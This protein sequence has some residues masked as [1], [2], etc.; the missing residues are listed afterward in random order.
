MHAGACQRSGKGGAG[1]IARGGVLLLTGLL[2]CSCSAIKAKVKQVAVDELANSLSSGGTVYSGDDSPYLIREATPFGLKLMETLLEASPEN[3]KLLSAV[4]QNF[5]QY[6]YAFVK[7]DAD[8]VEDEDLDEALELRAEARKLLLRGRDYALKGLET[9]HRGFS[10]Q[11]R[12]DPKRA[13]AKLTRQDVADAYWAG[14]AWGAAV[15]LA[16][17]DPSSLGDLP[18]VEA[19]MERV[20]RLQESFDHG[21]VHG[22]FISYEMT[23]MGDT[24]DNAQ[25]AR[26][27]FERA[28][29]LSDGLNA[30]YYVSLAEAVAV[31][32]ED[33]AEFESLLRQALA[34]DVDAK[35]EWR[36]ANL[37]Y[38]RRAKWLLSRTDRLFL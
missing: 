19:L 4:A 21:A 36:L 6:A 10:G 26:R 34:V 23:R 11:L 22:L 2:L 35:P 33:K 3:P 25:R 30:G 32:L 38:Q 12:A 24:A 14:A 9:R 13:V 5:T 29:A 7:Q 37:L 31:P 18:I 1:R 27:H 15:S 17:D 20:L 28:V 16:K 8:E